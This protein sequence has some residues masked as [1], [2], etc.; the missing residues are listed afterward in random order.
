M[1]GLSRETG[2]TSSERPR[3]KACFPWW[4]S[5]I[6]TSACQ[7]LSFHD[8]IPLGQTLNH[9]LQLIGIQIGD[10][11]LFM[12]IDTQMKE[13]WSFLG[14]RMRTLITID[15]P[16]YV[17]SGFHSPEWSND[18]ARRLL[19]FRY[20]QCHEQTLLQRFVFW[21]ADDHFSRKASNPSRKIPSSS[22]PAAANNVGKISMLLTKSDR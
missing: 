16:S 6:S 20:L 4:P 21:Q 2:P 5:T 3:Q 1:L 7:G 12:R 15:L 19:G 8:R 10:I 14:P 18:K 17:S 22:P 13:L 9:C 11:A